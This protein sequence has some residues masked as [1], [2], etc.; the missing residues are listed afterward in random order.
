M[1]NAPYTQSFCS[2]DLKYLNPVIC[3]INELVLRLYFDFCSGIFVLISTNA[4]EI[5]DLFGTGPM[6][7]FSTS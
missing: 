5:N 2:N 6:S 3:S 7:R 4:S 1:F